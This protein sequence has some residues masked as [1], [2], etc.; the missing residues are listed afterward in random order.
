LIP[1]RSC[2]NVLPHEMNKY[3]KP[4][5]KTTEIRQSGFKHRMVQ[6]CQDRWQSGAPLG[7]NHE[8]FGGC[9]GG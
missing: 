5:P 7:M 3:Y 9:G 6:L 4:L 8:N 1:Q 2:Q